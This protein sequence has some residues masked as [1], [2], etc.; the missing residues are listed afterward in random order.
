MFR[1][2]ILWWL[3]TWVGITGGIWLTLW[4][5][6]GSFD[7]GMLPLIAIPAALLAVIV[8]ATQC[9]GPPSDRHGLKRW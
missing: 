7:A 2:F 5:L 9:G 3:G 8:A 1:R 6:V 4:L